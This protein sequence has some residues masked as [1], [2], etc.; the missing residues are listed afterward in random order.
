VAGKGASASVVGQGVALAKSNV[1][2]HFKTVLLFGEPGHSGT[3]LF[4]SETCGIL[5]QKEPFAIF[6]GIDNQTK[7]GLMVPFPQFD[8]IEW[9][10]VYDLNKAPNSIIL[11]TCGKGFPFRIEP[12]QK[13]GTTFGLRLVDTAHNNVV[14]GVFLNHEMGFAPCSMLE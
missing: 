12:L 6:V 13:E 11:E 3:L 14:T 5:R 10:D 9:H 1:S 7:R 8:S 2:D 4:P